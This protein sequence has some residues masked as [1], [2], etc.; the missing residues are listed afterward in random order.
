MKCV[1]NFKIKKKKKKIEDETNRFHVIN[2][3]CVILLS[4]L[5]VFLGLIITLIQ[6]PIADSLQS[7]YIFFTYRTD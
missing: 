3:F 7:I 6:I 4:S 1:N 5:H 2:H